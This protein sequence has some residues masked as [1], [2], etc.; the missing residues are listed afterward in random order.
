MDLTIDWAKLEARFKG[1]R[2]FVDK[3]ARTAL[4]SQGD[5]PGKLRQA[6]GYGDFEA[7]AFAAHSLKGMSGNL[8]AD[9]LH[10]FAAR[11]ELAAKRHETMALD[12]AEL[13]AQAVERFLACLVIRIGD[14]AHSPVLG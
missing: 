5:S 14:Q 10:T 7:L 9:E 13:L 1:K 3:L 12:E 11:V 8:M 4:H 2:D 6:A